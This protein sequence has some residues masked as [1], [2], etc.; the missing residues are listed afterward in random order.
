MK[1]QSIAW[2]VLGSR[3]IL[4]VTAQLFIALFL[5]LAGDTLVWDESARWWI[6]LPIFA[7]IGSIVILNL[8]FRA[9]GKRYLD[10]LRFSRETFKT[11]LLWFFGSSLI[12]LPLA[13]APMNIFGAA[14]FGD[15]AI[16]TQMLFRPIPNWALAVGLLFPLTIGFAELPTYFGY[17]MPRLFCKG[18][19]QT[20]PYL[21]YLVAALFL[22][23]QHCFL[24]FIADWGFILWR[25]LMYL[26]FA[27]YVGLMVKLRPTLL[28]Y[29][30]VIHALMDFSALAVYLIL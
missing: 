18:E 8:V 28:P 5:F 12:G 2:L 30:A 17:A 15:P 11:D 24:P 19:S 6:F 20:R 21:A 3:S 26:P 7:N 29:F 25:G 9:E 16:P 27:L 10:I 14:I 1:S 4:F 13:A 23:A 22:S